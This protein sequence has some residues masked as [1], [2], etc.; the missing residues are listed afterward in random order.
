MWN[1]TNK[2][3]D[4]FLNPRNMGEIP[5]ADAIGEIGNIICGDAL[6]LY[7]KLDENEKIID[8]K[9]Q[10]F[11]CASAIASSSAL[12][13]IIKGMP[14]DEAANVT[15]DDIAAYLGGLPEEK[16]HCS[17]MGK[18]ALDKAIA[19]YRGEPVNEVYGDEH[20][21]CKCFGVTDVRILEVIREHKLKTVEEV[22]HY[23]KAGG[24]CAQC[25]PD[26]QELLDEYWKK[27][28]E[29]EKREDQEKPLTNLQKIQM[30]QETIK[31]EIEPYLKKDGGGIELIDILGNKVIVKF[32]GKCS[33]CRASEVTLTGFVQEKLREK[34]SRDLF[35]EE[36]KSGD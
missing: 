30:I 23:T 5:D 32:L 31:E 24:G 8:A 13:E 33:G 26:I 18:E 4:H 3:M 25:V 22:T 2:T 14:L 17:V 12:T 9:F 19:L 16:M 1:Y 15:D 36:I 11:G 27:T 28:E 10:T 21:V 34:V 29:K 35:V 6:K 7:L 20:I